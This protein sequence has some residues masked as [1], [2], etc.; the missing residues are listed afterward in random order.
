LS[1]GLNSYGEVWIGRKRLIL[2]LSEVLS[3]EEVQGPYMHL[4]QRLISIQ[5]WYDTRNIQLIKGR[6]GSRSN[7]PNLA[8]ANIFSIFELKINHKL[9]CFKNLTHR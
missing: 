1:R 3:V 4:N 7:R 2:K 6:W 8:V 5:K 9:F